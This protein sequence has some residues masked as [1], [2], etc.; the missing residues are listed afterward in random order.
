MICVAIPLACC[1]SC[2]FP[3]PAQG[4]YLTRMAVFMSMYSTCNPARRTALYT[5]HS[6][7]LRCSSN[8]NYAEVQFELN[9]HTSHL[10]SVAFSYTR[11]AYHELHV[12]PTTTLGNSDGK[13]R[14]RHAD[15]GASESETGEAS[16]YALTRFGGSTTGICQCFVRTPPV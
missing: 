13:Q 2:G 15:L 7:R 1:C 11:H 10:V 9:S 5:S 4:K 14:R 16:E 3:L 8:R 12:G 6:Q